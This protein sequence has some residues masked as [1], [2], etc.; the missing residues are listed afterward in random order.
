LSKC[1]QKNKKTGISAGINPQNYGLHKKT[2]VA[3]WIGSLG[4]PSKV[5]N[6][7]MIDDQVLGTQSPFPN[8]G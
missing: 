2:K 3:I 5:S 6:S 1:V 4:A 7:L 8:R